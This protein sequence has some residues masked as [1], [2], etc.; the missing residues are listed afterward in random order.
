MANTGTDAARHPNRVKFERHYVALPCS[1]HHLPA[2]HTTEHLGATQHGH[3]NQTTLMQHNK[4][5]SALCQPCSCSA[6][7]QYTPPSPCTP[8]SCRHW[9]YLRPR[10][11]DRNATIHRRCQNRVQAALAPPA[12]TENRKI[13]KVPCIPLFNYSSTLV[14]HQTHSVQGAQALVH[15]RTVK[16]PTNLKSH[17]IIIL[18]TAFHFSLASHPPVCNTF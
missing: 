6:S 18:P 11:H 12:Y 8:S 9:R 5:P 13:S 4:F 10:H 16:L 7:L 15:H 3:L 2:G 14:A 1:E 17:F